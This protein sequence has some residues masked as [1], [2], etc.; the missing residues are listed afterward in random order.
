M[1]FL[2]LKN[3]SIITR[4]SR[5]RFGGSRW[6]FL[7]ASF[8]ILRWRSTKSFAIASAS[9]GAWLSV[10]CF[11]YLSRSLR[12]SSVSFNTRNAPCGVAIWLSISSTEDV[13]D[14][15]FSGMLPISSISDSN[16]VTGESRLVV[17]LHM[18]S[19]SFVLSFWYLLELAVR[20][21]IESCYLS[22]YALFVDPGLAFL[23]YIWRKQAVT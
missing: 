17:P 13:S 21:S 18:T 14:V 11:F 6:G 1:Y 10:L 8:G 19:S 3:F 7:T 20:L 22:I 15:M 16:P 9:S 4:F 23:Q 12:S 2:Y 5:R